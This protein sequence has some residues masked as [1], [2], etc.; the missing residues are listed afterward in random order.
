MK[1][2]EWM[3]EFK[4]Y[5]IEYGADP[6]DIDELIRVMDKDI[7]SAFSRMADPEMAAIDIGKAFYKAKMDSKADK[8]DS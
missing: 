1:F 3:R 5:L 7:Q 2:E 6:T 4:K 8:N